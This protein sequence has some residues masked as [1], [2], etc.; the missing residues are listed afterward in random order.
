MPSITALNFIGRRRTPVILQ[1]EASECGLACLAMVASYH[2]YNTDLAAIQGRNLGVGRGAR[3]ADLIQ[4]AARLQLAARPVKVS[5]DDLHHLLR[6]HARAV[7]VVRVCRAA[8]LVG[9]GLLEG[10]P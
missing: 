7:G 8:A 1:N 10:H 9:F 4:I 3:L 2:G 5:L 6:N